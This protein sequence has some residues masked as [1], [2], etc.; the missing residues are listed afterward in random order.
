MGLWQAIKEK[1]TGRSAYT[2]DVRDEMRK[3]NKVLSQYEEARGSVEGEQ[4]GRYDAAYAKAQAK[5]NPPKQVQPKAVKQRFHAPKQAYKPAAVQRDVNVLGFERGV[6]LNSMGGGQSNN[7]PT[8]DRKLKGKG[9][10]QQN[11]IRGF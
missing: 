4:K 9:R 6:Q 5:Y 10:F 8:F 1:V 7:I 11:E 2:S 3:Q